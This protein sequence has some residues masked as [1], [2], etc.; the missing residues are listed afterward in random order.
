MLPA[1]CY[2]QIQALADANQVSS[3]WV[4]RHALLK[5]LN[6]QNAQLQL[7]LRPVEH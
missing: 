6:E 5:F 7:P 2:E 3:A 1:K 4:I